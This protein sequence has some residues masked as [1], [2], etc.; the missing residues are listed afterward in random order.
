MLLISQNPHRLRESKFAVPVIGR[1]RRHERTYDTHTFLC[2]ADQIWD[3]ETGPL[4]RSSNHCFSLA[5]LGSFSWH[6]AQHDVLG[7]WVVAYSVT[8]VFHRLCLCPER[9]T[10]KCPPVNC[11]PVRCPFPLF[12]P[13]RSKALGSNA[14]GQTTLPLSDRECM[15]S[16]YS[17]II[18]TG[19]GAML[20]R[21]T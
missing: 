12:L 13:S 14:P 17:V 1:G 4:S 6:W 3:G 18:V 8:E 16:V 5:S 10:V 11:P 19:I 20:L 7:E 21:K 9:C 15:Y 2:Q